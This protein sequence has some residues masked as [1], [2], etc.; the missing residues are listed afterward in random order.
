MEIEIEWI[1]LYN[2]LYQKR[3]LFLGSE[4]TD[5]LATHIVSIMI[6]LSIE[7][8]TQELY[9]YINSP[10]G[11]ILSGA[12]IFDAMQFVNTDVNTICVGLAASVASFVLA[13]GE[14]NK[15]LA[16]AHARIMIHQPTSAYFKTGIG[17]SLEDSDQI[18]KFRQ[19][20]SKSYARRIGKPSWVVYEDMER[21]FFMSAEEAQAHGIIDRI[22]NSLKK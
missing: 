6:Y 14:I 16:F 9:L 8:P 15:R 17:N 7:D 20:I 4:V 12:S 18:R 11:S 22:A 3:A 2:V 1:D 21:D 19:H 13:G 5:D 10:G